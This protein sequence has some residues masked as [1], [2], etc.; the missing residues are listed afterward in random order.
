MSEQTR[1]IDPILENDEKLAKA[2]DLLAFK[3]GILKEV[4]DF[5]TLECEKK[6]AWDIPHEEVDAVREGMKSYEIVIQRLETYAS[7]YK[8][9]EAYRKES[10]KRVSSFNPS[11]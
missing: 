2:S 11:V 1:V 6:I 9:R 4:L 7:E 3:G 10:L 8:R 5:L